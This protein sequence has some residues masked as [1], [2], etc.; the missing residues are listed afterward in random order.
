[1]IQM[2]MNEAD[3]AASFLSA[4]VQR[5]GWNPAVDIRR[6]YVSSRISAKFA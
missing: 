1:M 2:R 4:S 6:N 5:C 3:A